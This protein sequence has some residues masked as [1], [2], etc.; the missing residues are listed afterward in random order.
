MIEELKPYESYRAAVAGLPSLPA[1]WALRRTKSL[2]REIDRR[3]KT[4]TQRLL[5]LRMN[6]GLV[7][8][9]A[10]GGKHIPSSSLVGYKHVLPGELV[11][12]RMRAAIGLFG[13]A[14]SEGLVSPDYAIFDVRP[15]LKVEY[16]VALFKTPMMASL[17]RLESRGLGTGESGFLR[18]YSDR[19]GIIRMPLPPPEEQ[20]A[21]VRFLDHANR[22]IE[23]LVKS[24]R[25]EMALLAEQK[26]VIVERAVTRG[27]HESKLE[28]RRGLEWLGATPADWSVTR[29]KYLLREV[30]Q[31]SRFGTETLLSVRMHHGV[32]PFAEHFSRPPQAASLVGF[33]VV[34]PGQLVINRMQ[35]GNGVIFPSRLHGLVS[36]D[37]AV[38]EPLS[39]VSV[40]FLGELFRCRS[41]RTKFRS[42]SKGLGTGTSGFL[43]LYNDRL[44]AIHVALPDRSEQDRILAHLSVATR[45]VGQAR[46]RLE[47]EVALISEYR[48]RLV[49]DVVTGQLD[50]R[51]AAA[52]LPAVEP[53]AAPTET[54]GDE[55]DIEDGEAA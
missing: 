55:T 41:V 12:N 36:P 50:V 25:R 38:F 27:L 46:A 18:L 33:K 28:V 2:L 45:D 4:G 54:E 32:V 21:I 15:E 34:R 3:T 1:H 11:M 31:R 13:A 26:D 20:E 53:E 47:R 39:S 19:F 17:F 6:A 29:I 35:A 5:S 24:K 14:S 42:E 10:M 51:T 37:Y 8:H 30:D 22:R 40:D 43:R 23:Q 49:A 7:D 52:G 9:H 48:T 44:G 16:A